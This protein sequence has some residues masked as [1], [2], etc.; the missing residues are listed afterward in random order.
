MVP[1]F[2]TVCIFSPTP[3]FDQL[4]RHSATHELASPQSRLVLKRALSC[5]LWVSVMKRICTHS[6]WSNMQFAS[7]PTP[8]RGVRG[9]RGGDMTSASEQQS[10]PPAPPPCNRVMNLGVV[11]DL[12]RR[13]TSSGRENKARDLGRLS[14]RVNFHRV[15]IQKWKMSPIKKHDRVRM[16]RKC[17]I[18]HPI[19]SF[20]VRDY[21][22]NTR[23]LT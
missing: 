10:S 5:E 13:L 19:V 4:A 14:N 1:F 3:Y 21:N 9:V 2:K 7:T 17:L 23:K 20:D 6:R 8:G 11:A 16:Y 15:T 18:S 22:E 12:L